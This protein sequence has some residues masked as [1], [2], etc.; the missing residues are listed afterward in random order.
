VKLEATLIQDLLDL[1][2]IVNGD[3]KLEKRPAEVTQ[4]VVRAV[5]ACLGE[6]GAKQ[7]EVRR[8]L[9]AERCTAWVDPDR[10]QGAIGSAVSSAIDAAPAASVVRV[11]TH[12]GAKGEISIGVHHD[13]QVLE[14]AAMFDPFERGT[15]PEA[16]T[17]WGLGLRLAIGKAVVEACGGNVDASSDREGT[18]VVM[19]LPT[20]R[21]SA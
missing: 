13:G 14:P 21:C 6:A 18:S 7:I 11:W 19:T 16:P 1:A 15:V 12:D 20:V 10:L 9:A 4:I 5:D 3:F 17:A 2:R 8:E